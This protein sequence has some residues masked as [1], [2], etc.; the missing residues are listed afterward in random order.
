M[1]NC[2]NMFKNRYMKRIFIAFV[3]L[4]GVWTLSAREI[5]GKVTCDKKGLANVIVSDGQNF[6]LTSRDGEYSIELADSAA[7]VFLITPSGYVAD[8]SSGVPAFY[9]STSGE[10]FDFDLQKLSDSEEY[11]IVAIADP[12]PRYEEHF[13]QL[14]AEPFNDLIETVS[15]LRGQSVGLVLGDICFDVY[16]FLPRWKEEIVRVG[17]PFYPVVGNHDHNRAYSTEKEA[18]ELYRELFGPEN[19]AFFLGEDLVVVLDNIIY[20]G[21]RSNYVLGYPEE[22]LV[23]LENLLKYVPENADVFIG[24][25]APLNGR[26]YSNMIQN[27]EKILDILK[28]REATFLS[29][30]NHTNGV[31]FYGDNVIEHNVGAICGTHWDTY[32][33]GD[34]TPSGY[35]VLTK[36]GDALTWYYKSLYRPKDFQL[37]IIGVGQGRLNPNSLIVNVWDYAPT[38]KVEWHLNGVYQGPMTQVDEYSP[39]HAEELRKKYEGTGRTP[40]DYRLTKKGHHYF[41]ATPPSTPSEASADDKTMVTVVVTDPFGHVYKEN[42]RL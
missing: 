42:I 11:N 31:F 23:W 13:Q 20:D 38:W 9:R 19:Y 40:S 15:T 18:I 26:Y 36:K 4:L 30:H 28:D 17:I 33:C 10:C 25:H 7:F 1:K 32:H 37:E 12:Q 2:V 27:Y 29:G 6:S 24:Q 8:W 5:T 22:T 41:I 35:K 16:E 21:G 14:I 39:I 34:G 3:L